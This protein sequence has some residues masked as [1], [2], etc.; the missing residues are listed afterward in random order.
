MDKYIRECEMAE[1]LEF[2]VEMR[3]LDLIFIA[4]KFDRRIA[5]PV[6]EEYTQE[7]TTQDY[8]NL[9]DDLHGRICPKYFGTVE[10]NVPRIHKH[11]DARLRELGTSLYVATTYLDKLISDQHRNN[12]IQLRAA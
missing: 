4:S 5:S 2:V 12:V 11:V 6:G 9:H 3:V 7:W 8:L 10:I 1:F